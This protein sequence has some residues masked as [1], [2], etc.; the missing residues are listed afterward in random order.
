MDNVESILSYL[1]SFRT[2]K[3]NKACVDYVCDILCKNEILFKRIKC[4]NGT[5]ENIIAGINITEFKNINTGLILSGHLDTVG[6]NIKDW[7]TNPFKATK[8]DGNIYGRGTIDMKYFIA[9]ILS[10][11]S[12]LKK[13]GYPIFLLFSGDEETTVRGICQLQT[14]LKKNNILPKYAIVGEPSNFELCIANKGY[15]GYTTKIKGVAGHSCCP[16]KGVNAIYAASHIIS[17]IEKLYQKYICKQITL[18]VGAIRGGVQRN[19]IPDEVSFDWDI[20]FFEEK[21]KNE[22]LEQLTL[23]QEKLSKQYQQLSIEIINKES[24]PAFRNKTDSLLLKTAKS[25]SEAIV[26]TSL[27][28][29]EAGFLQ[30]MGIDTLICGAGKYQLAHTSTEHIKETELYDYRDFLLKLVTKVKSII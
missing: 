7:L 13:V 27:I 26:S 16:D 3:D 22:I 4:L 17:E 5:A 24:L 14:F 15:Y 19:S 6:V 18:S 21:Y 29:T 1:I 11:L 25:I 20:R 10:I 28:A 23:T 12:D 8:I 2:D 30:E 9:V